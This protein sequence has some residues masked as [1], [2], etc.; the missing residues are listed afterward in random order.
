MYDFFWGE[1]AD[2][3]IEAAKTRLYG[4]DEVLKS[5][6]QRVL[7]YA[8]ESILRLA[9]PFMP[10]ITEELWQAMPHTGMGVVGVLM[11]V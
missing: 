6:T 9:H 10:F 3:Y 1:F 7:V 11:W 5:S 2:W 8:Y 4:E